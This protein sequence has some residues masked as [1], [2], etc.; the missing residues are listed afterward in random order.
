MD[1]DDSVVLDG[2]ESSEEDF[3]LDEEESS[4]LVSKKKVNL[5]LVE[6]PLDER[7]FEDEVEFD[8]NIILA[9]RL[10]RYRGLKSFRNSVWSRYVSNQKSIKNCK[11]SFKILL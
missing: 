6:R 1:L 8:P 10:K 11:K 7:E 5:K 3:D 4:L 9:E 2:D